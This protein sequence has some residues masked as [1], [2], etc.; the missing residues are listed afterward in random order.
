MKSFLAPGTK[1]F[2]FEKYTSLAMVPKSTLFE[3]L[4]HFVIHTIGFLYSYKFDIVVVSGN[5]IL[6]YIDFKQ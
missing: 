6:I 3:L 1:V 5:G 4:W 2:P